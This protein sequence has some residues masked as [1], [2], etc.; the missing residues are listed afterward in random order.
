MHVYP[1]T[2]TYLLYVYTLIGESADSKHLYTNNVALLMWKKG[3]KIQNETWIPLR[4]YVFV[5]IVLP[6]Q[7]TGPDDARNKAPVSNVR[8]K[9]SGRMSARHGVFW[10]DSTDDCIKL[11]FPLQRCKLGYRCSLCIL[12][13]R[14]SLGSFC[15]RMPDTTGCHPFVKYRTCQNWSWMINVSSH[16]YHQQCGSTEFRVILIFLR[17]S[18]DTRFNTVCFCSGEWQA[19]CDLSVLCPL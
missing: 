4:Y 1:L 13:I 5:I 17:K 7:L 12:C 10:G 16:V 15:P 8:V 19:S 11:W 9:L 3:V 2:H 14:L 18:Q 6:W